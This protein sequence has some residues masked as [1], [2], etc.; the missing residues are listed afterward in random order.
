MNNTWKASKLISQQ[1][2]P[3]VERY[4]QLNL[5]TDGPSCSFSNTFGAADHHA[6]PA[7]DPS[8][9][10]QHQFYGSAPSTSYNPVSEAVVEERPKYLINY[11]AG[12]NTRSIS[13]VSLDIKVFGENRQHQGEHDINQ[14]LLNLTNQIDFIPHRNFMDMFE[15]PRYQPD[16]TPAP[17][18]SFFKSSQRLLNPNSAATSQNPNNNGSPVHHNANVVVRDQNDNDSDQKSDGQRAP[19]R[20][21]KTKKSQ[22]SQVRA[23]R[24]ADKMQRQSQP[25]AYSASVPSSSTTGAQLKSQIPTQQQIKKL[26]KHL[27]PPTTAENRAEALQPKRPNKGFQV[28][29]DVKIDA[30]MVH[31]GATQSS[32]MAKGTQQQ[33]NINVNDDSNVHPST[34]N[35]QGTQHSAAQANDDDVIVIDDDGAIVIDDVDYLGGSQSISDVP[36]FQGTTLQ[37]PDLYNAIYLERVSWASGMHIQAFHAAYIPHLSGPVFRRIAFLDPV[38]QRS[39]LPMQTFLRMFPTNPDLI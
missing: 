11:F 34:Q 8:T 37:A 14:K 6:A 24:K 13:P 18:I 33:S 12:L 3:N 1:Q 4:D 22:A 5:I 39:H 29:A 32:Q 17:E 10:K 25:A 26:P 27:R 35:L 38:W 21:R 30:N 16:G 2:D 20:R 31:N 9:N 7:N 36:T 15:F 28:L 23:R 19:K